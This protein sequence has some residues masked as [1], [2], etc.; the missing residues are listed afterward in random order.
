LKSE[1]ARIWVALSSSIDGTVMVLTSL[2][3]CF[4]G[5][6]EIAVARSSSNP[7]ASATPEHGT[8]VSPTFVMNTARHRV[9]RSTAREA[10]FAPGRPRGQSAA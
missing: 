5:G 6:R 1:R 9:D 3:G 10:G 7:R 8:R 4:V 2:P